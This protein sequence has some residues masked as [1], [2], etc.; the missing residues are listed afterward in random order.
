MSSMSTQTPVLGINVK[1]DFNFNFDQI[2]VASFMPYLFVHRQLFKQ[3]NHPGQ[4]FMFKENWSPDGYGFYR[5]VWLDL[6]L[7]LNNVASSAGISPS[8]PLVLVACFQ[9]HRYPLPPV[10]VGSIYVC[11]FT[12]LYLIVFL[13]T[14]YIL[15]IVLLHIV[16]IG[17]A[18]LL[19]FYVVLFCFLI[20]LPLLQCQCGVFLLQL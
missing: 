2:H 11:M 7:H 8:I 20:F 18:V 14:H 19:L 9:G 16:R 10:G 5:H 3:K 4:Q 17:H 13:T 6:R 15:Y 12:V 1:A